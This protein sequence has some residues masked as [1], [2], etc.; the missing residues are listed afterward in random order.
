MK[1]YR[2]VLHVG[3]ASEAQL[4]TGVPPH[5]DRDGSSSRNHDDASHSQRDAIVSRS[6][7]LAVEHAHAKNHAQVVK[8]V[9]GEQQMDLFTKVA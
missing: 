8:S 2:S 6:P 7:P 3:P 4:D 5:V 9:Q 1:N